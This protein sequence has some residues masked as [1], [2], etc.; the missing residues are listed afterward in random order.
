[1][2]ATRKLAAMLVKAPII[3]YR[4]TFSLFMGRE[5][6]Y[7]P[8]CSEYAEEAIDQNGPWKGF[9]LALARLA[10]CN[11]WGP[12]GFDPVPDLGKEHHPWWA[13]W[14]YGRWRGS[15]LARD[16]DKMP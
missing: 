8:T 6:C 11:P 10:R 3:F 14:R 1:M 9:W 5:C 16:L 12:S 15:D 7:L 4:Y 2:T 13:P